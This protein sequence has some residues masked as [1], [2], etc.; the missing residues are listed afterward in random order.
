[1]ISGF[2]GNIKEHLEN[3]PFLLLENKFS[4][5]KHQAMA[6]DEELEEFFT[7]KCI[8]RNQDL[9]NEKVIAIYDS[10]RV[11]VE[12]PEA[13]FKGFIS[14]NKLLETDLL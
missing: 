5:F 3:I 9:K 12:I 2:R 6:L 8:I 13:D 10:D 7:K 4:F 1:L 11:V 14:L